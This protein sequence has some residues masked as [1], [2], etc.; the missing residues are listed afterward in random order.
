MERCA[1]VSN[2]TI[3][4]HEGNKYLKRISSPVERDEKDRPAVIHVDVYA[5]LEAFDVRCPAIAHCLKKLLMPGQRGKGNINA[6]LKGA[7]AA[8]N[9]AIELEDIRQGSPREHRVKVSQPPPKTD[10]RDEGPAELKARLEGI[11]GGIDEG[12]EKIAEVAGIDPVE[13]ARLEHRQ[14]MED[15]PYCDDFP[16]PK[17]AAEVMEEEVE[18]KEVVTKYTLREK[19]KKMMEKSEEEKK[20]LAEAEDV[21]NLNVVHI[22][23]RPVRPEP[24]GKL[25]DELIERCEECNYIPCECTSDFSSSEG[26]GYEGDYE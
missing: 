4:Q 2:Q 18:E 11:T 15:C 1:R 8:L 19:I 26:I 3:K 16:C 21:M 20:L 10:P 6:D 25:L 17:H 14:A 7:M 13:L 24:P 22:P 12:L 5:V 23:A 9:R